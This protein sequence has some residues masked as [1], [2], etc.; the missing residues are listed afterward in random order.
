MFDGIYFEF[1]KIA[2]VIFFFIACETLCKMRLPSIYFPHSAQFIAQSISRSKLLFLL[3][4]LGIV[5][6]ILALMSPVKDEPYELKPK[7]GYAISLI[8]DASESMGQ[9]GFDVTNPGD[10]RFDVVKKIVKDFIQ[11]RQNDNLALVVFGQYSFIASPL[12]YD[13]NI[14][15]SLVMQMHETIAGRYTALYEGLVQGIRVLKQSKSKTKIAILLTDGYS[16]KGVDKIPLDVAIDMAKKEGVKVYPIGI[17]GANEYNRAVLAKIAKDT[18]GM[19]FGASSA[20]QLKSV[21]EQIDKLEKSEIKSETLSYKNYYY[22]YPLFLGFLSLMLYV[23]L[24]NKQ[25]GV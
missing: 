16:T 13:K 25:G 21:Y 7:E 14:L 10:S 12:T 6:L 18:G 19:A 15:A 2:F 20:G 3:K 5:M 1:P 24:R 9:R 4:W 8:L 23:Y 17:G 22:I 11:K